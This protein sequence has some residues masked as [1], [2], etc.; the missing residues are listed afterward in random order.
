MYSSLWFNTVAS[1]DESAYTIQRLSRRQQALYVGLQVSPVTPCT[2]AGKL[3]ESKTS[4]ARRES[5]Q[6]AAFNPADTWQPGNRQYTTVQG[7]A[8]M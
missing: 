3:V 2:S 1:V 4:G 8:Q 7:S 6:F 5:E